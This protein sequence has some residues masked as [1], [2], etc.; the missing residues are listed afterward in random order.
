M[1]YGELGFKTASEFINNR[2]LNY[3]F[4]LVKSNDNKL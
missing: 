4:N 3:W 1:L 2:M